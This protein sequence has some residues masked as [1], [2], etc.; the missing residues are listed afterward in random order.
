VIAVRL[1]LVA[2][3]LS[4]LA[5][6]ESRSVA[7][8]KR[9][10][11]ADPPLTARLSGDPLLLPAAASRCSNCHQVASQDE[12]DFGP[13]LTATWLLSDRKRRGGPPCHYDLESF[14]ALLRTGIDPA[15]VI[16]DRAM[17]R[18]ELDDDACRALWNYVRSLS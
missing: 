8:G 13:R 15:F 9:L 5:C 17:P 3:A 11:N 2:F 16:I 7:L 10:F 1:A 12:A 4:M 6:L 14:C 18:Y